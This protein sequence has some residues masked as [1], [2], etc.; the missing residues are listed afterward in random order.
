MSKRILLITGGT[1][2]HVIPAV[3]FANYLLEKKIDCKIILDKRGKEYVNN[4]SGKI[5][6]I[7]SSN[8]N[9]NLLLKLKGA[10]NFLIGF[11]L[12]QFSFLFRLH[13]QLL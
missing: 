6:T 5:Y 7:N 12:Q 2:G 1:G 3:N 13:H 8:F 10:I 4:F 9:G 11:L